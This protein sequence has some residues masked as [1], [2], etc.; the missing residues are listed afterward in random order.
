MLIKNNMDC[1]SSCA[2]ISVL[3]KKLIS[4]LIHSPRQGRLH[5]SDFQI[6]KMLFEYGPTQLNL[7][8]HVIKKANIL[9]QKTQEKCILRVGGKPLDGFLL[10]H[11]DDDD[12]NVTDCLKTHG[13]DLYQ[14]EKLF[15]GKFYC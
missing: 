14:Q 7:Y 1:N 13:F 3:Y 5:L 2:F 15:K 11:R 12:G 10:I 6:N 8:K 4:F 9:S